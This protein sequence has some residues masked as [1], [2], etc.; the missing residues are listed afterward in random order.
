ME[1][2]SFSA[3]SNVTAEGEGD[4]CQLRN[5]AHDVCDASSVIC[6]PGERGNTGSLGSERRVWRPQR[7]CSCPTSAAYITMKLCM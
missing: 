3:S 2:R 7:R 5:N 1:E 6:T 4:L